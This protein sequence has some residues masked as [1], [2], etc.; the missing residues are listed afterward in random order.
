[1]FSKNDHNSIS[2]RIFMQC[3]LDNPPTER[4]QII[5]LALELGWT[6]VTVSTSGVW[7]KWRYVTSKPGP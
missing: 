4:V 1:M 5:S 7:R 3:V 6:S 2:Y